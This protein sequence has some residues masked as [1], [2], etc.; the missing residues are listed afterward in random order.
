MSDR[1]LFSIGPVL[2]VSFWKDVNF[3]RIHFELFGISE[4][5]VP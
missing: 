1:I 5:I 3:L 4:V 2:G